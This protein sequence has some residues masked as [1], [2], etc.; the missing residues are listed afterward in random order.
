[1]I[2]QGITVAAV[3]AATLGFTGVTV[4]GGPEIAP[5]APG[6]LSGFYMGLGAGYDAGVIRAQNFTGRRSFLADGSLLY[7]DSRYGDM[8]L[9]GYNAELFAGYG[10]N[11]YDRYYLGG[12]IFGS[13]NSTN[14]DYKNEFDRSSRPNEIDLF[15]ENNNLKMQNTFG[16]G[17]ILGYYAAPGSMLYIR[18]DYVNSNFKLVTSEITSPFVSP[19]GLSPSFNRNVSG[20]QFGVGVNTRVSQYISVRE[21]Y[22]WAGYGNINFADAV[23][24][25]NG[26]SDSFNGRFSPQVESYKLSANYYFM[27][28]GRGPDHFAA[29]LHPG[30]E[31]YAGIGASREGLWSSF[32]EFGRKDYTC[33]VA[34]NDGFVNYKWGY[35]WQA[36]GWDGHLFLGAAYT[37]DNRFS[38]GAEIFGS[39]NSTEGDIYNTQIDTELGN[40]STNARLENDY[41]YG[42]AVLPGYH[43]S[44]AATIYTRIGVV[45]SDFKFT[46][47]ATQP[48]VVPLSGEIAAFRS[49]ASWTNAGL[50]VG[51]GVDTFVTSNVSVRMEFDVSKY[52]NLNSV[53]TGAG[54]SRDVPGHTVVAR[55]NN[56][57]RD[58]T[59]DSFN[60]SAV[61][62]FFR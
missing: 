45:G 46:S 31:Y 15:V 58:V 42:I 16:I 17:A 59:L 47:R 55:I 3:L 34:C 56:Q 61:Y 24:R 41:N 48:G 53:A 10:W 37:F 52:C 1:M 49:S 2:K 28:D 54:Q 40:F 27:P 19:R 12:E 44:D 22:T 29:P 39:I 7:S 60:V 11:F 18:G 26:D 21:E 14:G 33:P 13:V 43:V 5:E 30:V 38:L 51:L 62:H 20:G 25:L 57:F 32:A 36:R 50:I 6:Y 8:G 23:T 4:A 9:L 35:D